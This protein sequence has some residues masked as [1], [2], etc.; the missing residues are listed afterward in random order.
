MYYSISIFI[1]YLG[2]GIL[3]NSILGGFIV[4]NS[5]RKSSNITEQLIFLKILRPIGL[6]GP[7][8]L[9]IMLISGIGNLM[10]LGFASQDVISQRWLME[11]LFMF[12]LVLI[13]GLYSGIRSKKRATLIE[14][15]ISGNENTK[16]EKQKFDKISNTFLIIQT[17]LLLA[18]LFRSAV[19]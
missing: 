11:K 9:G 13:I 14:Q 5:Y 19:K 4:H 6:L 3:I 2:I 16:I 7:I 17:I 15:I 10:F 1:H 12:F 8:G 18:I